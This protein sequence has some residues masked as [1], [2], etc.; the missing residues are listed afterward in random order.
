MPEGVD[1]TVVGGAVTPLVD[2]EQAAAGWLL[3][4][5]NAVSSLAFVVAA[6]VLAAR[7]GQR[8][9]PVALAATGIGSFLFHGPV[10]PGSEW[11]H[12]VSLAW[13]LAVAGAAGT[14]WERTVGWTTLV[15]FGITFAILP[16]IAD[17]V[18]AVTAVVA[19]AAIL[20]RDRS[21]RT[22]AALA[23]LG[24]G[25]VVGR[26]SATGALWCQPDSLLQGHAF[27]HLA[28][29]TAVT[30]WALGLPSANRP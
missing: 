14:R 15:A 28:A 10:P 27:W 26:L 6:I 3:Q 23:L 18:A 1:A 8:W 22:L 5:V 20:W 12:D 29:A 9:I 21:R 25:A 11:A 30:V 7:T 2:C 4:P 24:T 17:P 13:L 16:V 19:I